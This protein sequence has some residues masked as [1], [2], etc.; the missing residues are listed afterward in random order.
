MTKQELL[1]QIQDALQREAPLTEN[2]KLREIEEWDSL[3]VMAVIMI[4]D[5]NFGIKLKT[6]DFNNFIFI[7]DIIKI[8]EDKLK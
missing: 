8:V 6:A 5:K 2:L 1:N 4:I 3:A 7:S